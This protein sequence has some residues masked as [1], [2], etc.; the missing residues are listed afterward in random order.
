MARERL[1][2]RQCSC[3]RGVIDRFGCSVGVEARGKI[4]SALEAAEGWGLLIGLWGFLTGGWHTAGSV[5]GG[6]LEGKA[7]HQSADLSRW[8]K[9]VL[10]KRGTL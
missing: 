8:S 10:H 6:S 2:I 4:G 7:R 3:P 1:R 9:R 5:E